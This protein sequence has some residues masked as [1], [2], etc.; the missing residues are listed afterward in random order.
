MVAPSKWIMS[1][2]STWD[3]R[4]ARTSLPCAV[5]GKTSVWSLR[6]FQPTRSRYTRGRSRL[7]QNDDA[8]WF[9]PEPKPRAMPIK[10]RVAFWRG[11]TIEN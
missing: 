8:A 5:S 9:Y 1:T 7:L 10:N 2:D 11:V 6:E 4:V 3:P